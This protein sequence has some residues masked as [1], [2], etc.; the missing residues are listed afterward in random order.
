MWSLWPLKLRFILVRLDTL[1]E[2]ITELRI[3]TLRQTNLTDYS[4]GVGRGSLGGGGS[5][6]PHLPT[7]CIGWP[8]PFELV[9][10]FA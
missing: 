2:G 9:G 1:K 8:H 6:E 10:S 7:H 5:W 4:S 3:N